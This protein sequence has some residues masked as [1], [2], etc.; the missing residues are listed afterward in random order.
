M[1][2]RKLLRPDEKRA[3]F[4]ALLAGPEPF[5]MPGGVGPI[6]AM[7][8]EAAGFESFFLA[9]S[10]IAAMLFGLPDVGL[11]GLRD[12]VDHA[13]H[14]AART[15]IPIMVDSDTGFGNAVNV[16]FSVQDIL[17]SGASGL[18]IE[19]QEAPK[20][21]GTSSGR[22][23]LAVDEAVG[24]YR[25]AVAARD[26]LDPSFVICAR[27]DAIGAERESFES[28]VERC[29]TY[30]REGRVDVVWLNSVQTCEQIRVACAAIPAPVLIAWGGEG[31]EPSIEDYRQM[32][33]RVIKI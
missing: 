30:V 28:A 16:H 5:I 24:K 27:T 31:Q 23:C 18:Q 3:R 6:H 2:P 7:M 29:V 26:Q 20:K 4:R 21:S 19:D 33:A 1:S 15:D 13:R 10:Q 22:R 25:A 9:G 8:A 12:V 17:R 32:W 14:V 11:I